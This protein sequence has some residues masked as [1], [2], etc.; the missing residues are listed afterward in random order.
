LEILN[1]ESKFEQHSCGMKMLYLWT[2]NFYDSC[3]K[4]TE[5]VEYVEYI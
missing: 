3:L 5:Y 2:Q 4:P 1:N